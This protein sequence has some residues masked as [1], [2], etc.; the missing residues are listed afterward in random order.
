MTR[1]DLGDLAPYNGDCEGEAMPV[2]ARALREAITAADAL[3]ICTPEY[4]HGAPGVLLNAIDWASRPAFASPLRGKPVLVMST[5]IA[6]TG[7]VRAHPPLREAFASTLSRVVARPEVAV[8]HVH[9]KI[10]D[11]VFS[12]EPS[13]AYALAA[14]DDLIAE[15]PRRP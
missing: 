7:G 2:S 10:V 6:S 12:H 1:F 8:A 3:V 13:I 4:N 15:I 5:S 11:G 9:E 14:I